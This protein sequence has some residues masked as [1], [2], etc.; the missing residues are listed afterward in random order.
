V[1]G[2]HSSLVEGVPKTVGALAAGFDENR[3]LS[4]A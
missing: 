3:V 4:A 1:F 2:L